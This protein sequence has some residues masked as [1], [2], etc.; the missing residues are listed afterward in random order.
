LNADTKETKKNISNK[1]NTQRIMRI[2]R[3]NYDNSF[4]QELKHE[5]EKENTREINSATML[6]YTLHGSIDPRSML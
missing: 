5:K 2:E 3:N 1:E 6:S 4:N